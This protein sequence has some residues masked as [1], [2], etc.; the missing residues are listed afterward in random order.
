MSTRLP[1]SP[2]SSSS[3][4]IDK[5]PFHFFK[6]ITLIQF[7]TFFVVYFILI[8]ITHFNF[9]KIIVKQTEEQ[10][11]TK[12]HLL[13]DIFE[14]GNDIKNACKSSASVNEQK[15]YNVR[16]TVIGWDGNIVCDSNNERQN[17]LAFENPF[18][19]SEVI[20]AKNGKIAF[21]VRYSETLSVNMLYGAIIVNSHESSFGQSGGRAAAASGRNDFNK[22]GMSA[23]RPD[24]VADSYYKQIAGTN[25][26]P[27]AVNID[28]GKKPFIL[29]IAIPLKELDRAIKIFDSW[30]IIVLIPF[31]LLGPLFIL[32]LAYRFT[33][34]IQ[35]ILNKMY[36]I[37]KK[38]LDSLSLTKN[39]WNE[40]KSDNRDK[41]DNNDNNNNI[42]FMQNYNDWPSLEQMLSESENNIDKTIEQIRS[43]NIKLNALFESTT[44]SVVAINFNGVICFTN[45]NFQDNFLHSKI[46]S[47]EKGICIWEIIRDE[48]V[49]NAFKKTLSEGIV[50]SVH[51]LLLPITINNNHLHFDLIITPINL[52]NVE[53]AKTLEEQTTIQAMGVFH[54]ISER[55]KI[56]QIKLD[57][58]SNFSH[59]VKTPLSAINGLLQV[60][61]QDMDRINFSYESSFGLGRNAFNNNGISAL[62]PDVADSKKEHHEELLLNLKKKSSHYFERIDINLKKMIKLFDDL[63]QLSNIEGKHKIE[64]EIFSTCLLTE[65]IALQLKKIYQYKNI[66]LNIFIDPLAEEMKGDEGLIEL[67]LKNLLENAYKYTREDGKIEIRWESNQQGFII[68]KV[69]D[70]GIGIPLLHQ[71][72]IF[73]RFY[74]VNTSRS[75]SINTTLSKSND[76]IGFGLGLAVVKHIVHKHQGRIELESKENI[77]SCFSLYF[78]QYSEE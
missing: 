42:V 48:Q 60:F 31:V 32:W 76:M 38:S 36:Q 14:R 62:L 2:T 3:Q 30:I 41:K 37:N 13:K 40:D 10:L 9:K 19:K 5:L 77:G 44:N 54:D 8:L 47:I 55:K 63:L 6:K 24:D 4:I 50:C 29:R 23:L 67:V 72:R 58:I 43:E 34:S 78:N 71:K 74:Q 59:E 26:I 53:N 17:D 18:D 7:S 69:K 49:E 66:S 68:L 56:E 46:T 22:N 75:K 25:I 45:K 65:D 20:S 35:I 28:Y 21:V 39:I 16:I 11:L 1:T 73:E 70:D 12:L 57:F 61:Q 15:Y 33:D 27:S 64:K 52:K 51:D